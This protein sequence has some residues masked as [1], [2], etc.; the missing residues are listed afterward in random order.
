MLKFAGMTGTHVFSVR[1]ER[2]E[3]YSEFL[4]RTVKIDIYIPST[5][6]SSL[7]P[8]DLLIINDGQDLEPM[9]FD[10]ILGKM[11]DEIKPL[12]CAGIHCGH[13]RKMEYGI[14]G[15]S[16]FKGRGAK[17]TEYADFIFKEFI[18]YIEK[19]FERHGFASKSYAGFSLGGLSALDIVWNNPTEF[20]RVGVFS[21]S[22]W[23]RSVDQT[24][25][26]YDDNKHRIMHQVIRKSEF[27]P[28]LEFFFQC[29]NM[30]ETK[31]RNNN[32][33]IDSID[34]TQD[35]IKELY[36]KGYNSEDIFYMELSDGRHDVPTSGRAFPYFLKW[37]WGKMK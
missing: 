10:L 36:D 14:I 20:K 9:E 23:W 28:G 13:D 4:D 16:D 27:K 25:K 3:L 18:P 22:L 34:D 17:A 12:I 1:T 8:P 35:L 21:G 6:E 32:G 30:D 11:Q 15:H 5:A 7:Q 31:D 19:K 29:G 2:L 33:I 24:D 37:G 26:N